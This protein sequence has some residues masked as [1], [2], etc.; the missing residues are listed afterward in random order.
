M[1]AALVI[2]LLVLLSVSVA[3][4]GFLAARNPA[5]WY[6]LVSAALSAALPKIA[7]YVARRNTPDIEA[8]MQE[9][10]RRGGEWDNFRKRCK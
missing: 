10:I 9:C 4:G 5:F 8:K 3:A 7:E 2:G 1:D 6:G